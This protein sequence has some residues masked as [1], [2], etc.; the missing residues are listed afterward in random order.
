MS[1]QI[2]TSVSSCNQ[3]KLCRSSCERRIKAHEGGSR[4]VQLNSDLSVRSQA[5]DE[6]GLTAPSDQQWQSSRRWVSP[7]STACS[8]RDCQYMSCIGC[9]T[10]DAGRASWSH[11]RSATVPVSAFP[12]TY[13]RAICGVVPRLQRLHLTL[14]QSPTRLRI[15]LLQRNRCLHSIVFVFTACSFHGNSVT[16][17]DVDL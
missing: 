12:R 2:A 8:W 17:C 3:N 1:T 11:A 7:R 9:R 16:C 5:S 4:S 6:S 13:I 14:T 10:T 15:Y